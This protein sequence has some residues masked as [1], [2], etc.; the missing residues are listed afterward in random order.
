MT[1]EERKELWKQILTKLE[2]EMRSADFRT[3]MKNTAVLELEH[4]KLIVGCPS[5]IVRTQ[6][7][8]KHHAKILK[9]VKKVNPEMVHVDYRVEASLADGGG[10]VISLGSITGVIKRAIR[11]E[12]VE[13]V[14]VSEGVRSRELNPDY[15]F[16]TFVVGNENRIAHAAAEA[17]AEK[18]GRAYNPLFIYGGVGLGKTHL[19]QSIGNAVSKKKNKIV[20]YTTSEKFTNEII[21]AIKGGVAKI[22]KFRARFRKVDLLMIDDVQ[23]LAGKKSTQEEFFHTFNVLHEAK[24]QIVLAADR[25]PREMIGMDERLV[26]RFGSGMIADVVLPN[27]ETRVAIL[28]RFAGDEKVML[29]AETLEFVA[30]NVKSSIRDLRGVMMQI[31]ARMKLF[32]AMPNEDWQPTKSNVADIL[33]KSGIKVVT[34]AQVNSGPLESATCDD[35]IQAAADYFQLPVV[36]VIGKSRKKEMTQA[37]AMAMWLCR[38]EMKFG[39][40]KIGHAFGNRNHATVMHAVNKI[41]EELDLEPSGTT[42]EQVNG[43]KRRVE[44]ERMGG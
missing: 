40:E 9:C 30:Q 29:P 35:F 42:A 3:W 37:R 44:E 14:Q 8:G 24:K 15:T 13:G 39:F 1:L 2:P 10:G 23:F 7:A 11:R 38:R 19:L 16:E 5:D 36:E 21:S 20:V 43:I 12:Q 41:Q 32:E 26:S 6:L 33:A 22:D 27:F 25:P 34:Q 4:D 28:Q 31:A 17:V 18:P